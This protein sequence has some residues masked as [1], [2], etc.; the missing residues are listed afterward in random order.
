MMKAAMAAALG[1]TLLTFPTIASA[2]PQLTAQGHETRSVS[3]TYADLDLTTT[4]GRK[5]LDRRITHAARQ[6]CGMDQILTGTRIV[7]PEARQCYR[8][9]LR[10]VRQEMAERVATENRAG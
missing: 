9:A 2:Q 5:E 6:V 8:K 7:P 4:D 10:Q 3:V 1:A